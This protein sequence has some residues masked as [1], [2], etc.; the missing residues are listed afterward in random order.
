VAACRM[1]G[2]AGYDVAVA[3][4]ERPAAAQWSRFCRERLSVVDPRRDPAQFVA[5][6]ERIVRCGGYDVLLPGSDATLLALAC[7]GEHLRSEVSTGLPSPDAVKRALSKLALVEAAAKSGH[8]APRT[9]V[10]RD[11][12]EAVAAADTLG[13]PVVLKP[14]RSVFE[15]GGGLRQRAS[16]TVDDPGTLKH[17]AS[18]FGMPCLVQRRE[19]GSVVSVGGVIVGGDL[20][21]AVASRY[22]RT[23]H[24]DAGSAAYSETIELTPALARTTSDFVTS[25][26][27]QGIFELELLERPEGDL[28]PIDFNPRVYGSLAL[29]GAVGVP[30][31]TIWANWL[32]GAPSLGGIA[33][34]G[35]RYRWEDADV[36]GAVWH[37]SRGSFREAIAIARPRRHTVHAHLWLS[38]PLPAAARAG[39]MV[40]RRMA[41]PPPG[42]E[43]LR[44]ETSISAARG[45]RKRLR[46]SR[47]RRTTAVGPK[48]VVIGAGPY[49]L[50]AANFCRQAGVAVRSFGRSMES[51]RQT[52]PAGMILR[53]RWRSSHIANPTGSLSL[54]HFEREI[55]RALPH[56]IAIA[57]FI[58]YGHWYQRQAVPD[59]DE[60]R[61]ERVDSVAGGFEL[62]LED[63]E[64]CEAD[65]VI[66]A[67]GLDGFASR[68]PPFDRL[69]S[70]LVSHTVD[71]CELDA[72]AGQRVLVVGA[73]QSALES[74]ALLHESG[75]EVEVLART[76]SLAFLAPEEITGIVRRVNAA[77]VPPTDV[78]GRLTG[79]GAAAPDVYRTLPVR[80][81]SLIT[82]RALRPRGADW[83]RSRLEDVEITLGRR[84]VSASG[85]NGG[86]EVMLDDGAKR[87]VN[88]V[89]LGTGYRVDVS[90]YRFLSRSL[91]AQLQLWDGYPILGPRLE[92]TVPGLHFVGAPAAYSFGPIMRFVVGT[93]YAAPAV[94]AGVAGGRDRPIRFAYRPRRPWKRSQRGRP[95]LPAPSDATRE[96]SKR[97]SG[98]PVA[99]P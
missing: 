19:T 3:A 66:V 69:P 33:R 32:R 34:A 25:I 26:G 6:L 95:T 73:G 89:L 4:S 77:I 93:W 63:G 57:D 88:H 45:P 59:L 11:P 54:E 62:T 61:V 50:S 81:R 40:R 23:W 90:S 43:R 49:G 1:L 70:E 79:W 30:L 60:R 12:G 9:V 75:A 97:L 76:R 18:D 56:H 87:V 58:D 68:P 5:D 51:W 8:P 67:A 83:L 15:H 48:V 10:C 16:V 46:R 13:Y 53:S 35:F 7:H 99:I 52:M 36:Q 65:K 84:A 17:L 86:I 71:H 38:D 78:G 64:S 22:A 47:R 80:A 96:F 27:W 91:V 29:A 2:Q 82:Q 39:L 28:L 94:T 44:R 98:D 31:A 24:P 20:L 85:D 55:G 21:G 42:R 72:F 41:Q 37:L 14:R 74:A 92:S